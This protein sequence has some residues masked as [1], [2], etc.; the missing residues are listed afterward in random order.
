M[1]SFGQSLEEHELHDT[2]ENMVWPIV[3]EVCFLCACILCQRMPQ[4]SEN[5][6]VLIEILKARP[7]WPSAQ[8]LSES[9]FQSIC[10]DFPTSIWTL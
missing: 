6:H 9:H 1:E 2:N 3:V 4:I 5:V 7:V 10:V 8:K